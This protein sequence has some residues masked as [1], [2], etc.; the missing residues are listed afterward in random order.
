MAN[1]QERLRAIVPALGR[2]WVIVVTPAAI[3]GGASGGPRPETHLLL[4]AQN[5]PA[6]RSAAWLHAFGARIT[7]NPVSGGACRLVVAKAAQTVRDWHRAWSGRPSSGHGNRGGV[8]SQCAQQTQPRG[9]PIR[10]T[11]ARY[12]LKKTQQVYRKR[13]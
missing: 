2:A 13:L 10:F 9:K 3:E 12:E 6:P 11:E 7:S 8:F 5:E 4:V 1:L